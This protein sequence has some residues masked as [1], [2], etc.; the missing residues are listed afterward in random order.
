MPL[1]TSSHTGPEIDAAITAAL[2]G[3]VPAGTYADL[4]ALTAAIPEGNSN[5]YLTTDNNKWNYWNGSAWTPGGT[6]TGASASVSVGT[7]TTGGPGTDASVE[8]SGTDTNAVFDFTI[9]RGADG[10]KGDK[11]DAAATIEVGTTTTGDPGTDAA[12]SNGGTSSAVVLHFTI[13]RGA[14]GATGSPGADGDDGR[15]IVS[16][17]RTSGTGTAGTTDTYTITYSDSTTSTF[18]VYNGADGTGSGD[19]SKS[20]YDPNNKNADAFALSNMAED[21]AHRTVSDT[22]KTAWNSKLPLSGGTMTG[23]INEALVSS[24]ALASTMNIGAAAGNYI[25]V[26]AGTGPITAFDSITMG[27]RRFLRFSV[28][29][30]ITYNATSMLLPGTADLPVAAGDVLEFVSG[31]SGIW[32]CVN[33]QPWGAWPVALGGTGASTAAGARTNIG[34]GTAGT[35]ASE[36]TVSNSNSYIPT[37]GAVVAHTGR[38]TAVT[39]ADT[40]YTSYMARGEALASSDTTPSYNGQVCWTYS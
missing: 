20:V 4:A 38:S 39:A 37:G 17:V 19:M 3:Y 22:E 6:Y 36:T 18:S 24:M 9:P 30:T 10:E 2:A 33:I 32:R 5:V 14:T 26:T 11:G 15:S 28:A 23:A 7:V 25:I 13:P 1:Y 40:N 35:L 16:V 8:N 12:V 34:V 27:A 21:S 31:G 29:T